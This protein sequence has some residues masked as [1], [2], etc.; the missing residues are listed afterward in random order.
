M[1]SFTVTCSSEKL[2]K[3]F[4]A[5]LYNFNFTVICYFINFIHNITLQGI[6]I[7]VDDTD[8]SFIFSHL[9]GTPPSPLK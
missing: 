7:A 3:I 6:T 2:G 1:H 5:Y 9:S 8:T 4:I